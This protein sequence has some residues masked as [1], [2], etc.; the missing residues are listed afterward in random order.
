MSISV[1]RNDAFQ[2]IRFTSDLITD[3]DTTAM[4]S[5]VDQALADGIRK[6]VYSI[7]VGSVSNLILIARVLLQSLDLARRGGGKVCLV[8]KGNGAPAAYQSLCTAMGIPRYENEE[9]LFWNTATEESAPRPDHNYP[10]RK[11]GG[12]HG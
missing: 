10:T 9:M 5:E 8:E 7:S 3:S 12:S 2:I 11:H 1:E 4:L 6:I